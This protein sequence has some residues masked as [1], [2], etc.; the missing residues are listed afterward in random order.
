MAVVKFGWASS[1]GIGFVLCEGQPRYFNLQ[2][3]VPPGGDLSKT[4][5][6]AFKQATFILSLSPDMHK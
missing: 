6:Y 5:T 1:F 2:A 3:S 4:L